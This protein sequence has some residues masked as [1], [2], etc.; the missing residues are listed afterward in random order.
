MGF[1]WRETEAD[2]AMSML[3]FDLWLRTGNRRYLELSV[4]YNEDDCRATKVVRE[5]VGGGVTT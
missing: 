1:E 2:A 5:W 4:E 3:W